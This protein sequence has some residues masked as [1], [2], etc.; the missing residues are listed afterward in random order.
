[1][2]VFSDCDQIGLQS[3]K[4]MEVRIRLLGQFTHVLGFELAHQMLLLFQ[5]V[6]CQA[7]FLLEEL[8]GA[9]HQLLA[10]LEVLLDEL[11]G[12]FRGH[13][14]GCHRVLVREGY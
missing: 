14:H 4:G 13:L 7:Q 3:V 12:E 1:M 9:F 2:D 11:R 10:D 6:L 8:G 5:T